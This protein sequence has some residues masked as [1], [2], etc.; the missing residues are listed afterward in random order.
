MHPF[1]RKAG[2]PNHDFPSHDR[3]PKAQLGFE[4]TTEVRVPANE[5][6][7]YAEPNRWSP[8]SHVTLTDSHDEASGE[9]SWTIVEG[10][11]LEHGHRRIKRRRISSQSKELYNGTQNGTN[12]IQQTWH[13][14]LE[15]AAREIPEIVVQKGDSQSDGLNS[16][17]INLDPA[18]GQPN[19]NEPIKG[20]ESIQPST[21]PT[22]TT[23]TQPI[24]ISAPENSILGPPTAAAPAQERMS[25]STPKTRIITLNAKGK[26]TNTPNPSPRR[27]AR[28]NNNDAND[29]SHD[30][31]K[32][33]RQSKK[34]GMKNGKFVSSL[35]L[36][37]RHPTKEFGQKIEAILSSKKNEPSASIVPSERGRGGTIE[38][39]TT[40]PFFLGKLAVKSEK[41]PSVKSE[42]SSFAPPSEDEATNPQAPKA[43]KD[44]VFKSQKPFQDK[45]LSLLSSIWP[46]AS[47]QNI[48]PDKYVIRSLPIL[49]P[50]MA[51][52]KSKQRN[53]TIRGDEDVLQAF[54]QSLKHG[55]DSAALLHVPTRRI[56]SGKEL[57]DIINCEAPTAY[58][59][60]ARLNALRDP[61]I[62]RIESTP[63]PFDKGMAAGPYMWTQG[64]GP[65]CW[66]EVLQGQSQVLY[67]WLSN[68]QIHQVQ[69]GKLQT[70][71]KQVAVKRA[72]KRKS[73]GMDDFI[74][75]SDDET[76][77]SSSPGKNAILIVGPSGCGKTASVYA[78]AQQLGFEVFEIHPGMRRSA[79][80]IQ[81][82]VGDMTQN[83]LVQQAHIQSGRPGTPLDDADVTLPMSE[84][85][86]ASQHSI[87][88]FMGMGKVEKK[89]SP[90][91]CSNKE[92]KARAQKQSLIL[93]EE[94]DI[95]FEE[96]KGF[97]TGVQ[98]LISNSKRPV[99]MTCNDL[100]SIPLDELDLFS[101][102]AFDRPD[103]VLAVDHLQCIA[104]AE[105]HLL[106]R[107]SI[108]NLY[109]S[110]GQDLRAS[111]TELN[112]WCQ[113]TLGSH[114]GGLDW[115][116]PHN[117]KH[118]TGREGSITRIVSQDTFITGLDLLPVQFCDWGEIIGYTQN[119]LDIS[120][121]DWVKDDFSTEVPERS[122][123]QALDK[124]LLLSEARS[125]MDLL[126]C[127]IT[128]VIAGMIK[129]SSAH[130]TLQRARDD[131]VQL[132]VEHL[133]TRHMSRL[134]ITDAFETLM[135][136][137]RIGLPM[138][139]GRKAPSL[140]NAA[141]SVVTDVAP[142]VRCIVA[143]DQRLEQIRDELGGGPQAKRQRKTRAARAALEGG[144]KGSV[145]RDKWFPEG[146]DF[147]AVLATGNTWPQLK[148]EEAC[149]APDTPS[150]SMAT[151]TDG[152]VEAIAIQGTN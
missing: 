14:Q 105:G 47:I 58:G 129:G 145:R 102:L 37:L 56:M 88:S 84:S 75:D 8:T 111:I 12:T 144:S 69:T 78:V 117:E 146:L 122:C 132:H 137:N 57:A 9:G 96:D 39:K 26:L 67:D 148:P 92:T 106:D 13:D 16:Q 33:G 11:D 113:M 50:I 25:T 1:F 52:L 71:P 73:D 79:R 43:W 128:P 80:D 82:K 21:D 94:V 35:Q 4:G 29:Q 115:M 112:L 90:T 127:E 31:K 147:P 63:S 131:L 51:S 24:H 118:Q 15:A 6:V 99:I 20:P 68:L 18:S 62:R 74:A 120:A 108:Q 109:A 2:V 133:I 36:T 34:I 152:E 110:K 42:T 59:S 93:F 86:P 136:D 23:Q 46:P 85:L 77:D 48:Q 119:D 149:F 126:D 64:Y 22:P 142:Y 130:D 45:T 72:R 139:P 134:D 81:E 83:H 70:N 98:S 38:N 49:P 28:T 121:L 27:S 104:A 41:Q 61:L 30:V 91:G 87:A 3:S 114:Q 97:W 54:A 89:K 53:S 95:L 107:Q 66:Q 124:A 55:T 65:T 135:E 141:Q 40:H 138:A 125:A 100:S 103:P 7:S 76:L 19:I 143:H 10:D 150:S 60:A 101:V 123:L 5:S 151:A 140:D 17:P 32:S 44:I 116:L